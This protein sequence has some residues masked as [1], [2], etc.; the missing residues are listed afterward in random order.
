MILFI[1]KPFIAGV[2]TEHHYSL[3]PYP[4]ARSP[5]K[6]VAK[7]LKSFPSAKYSRMISIG[8]LKSLAIRLSS[9]PQYRGLLKNLL[10]HI[11]TGQNATAQK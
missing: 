4:L 5:R 8:L 3:F 1:K 10:I 6:S 2:T 7:L 11:Y 9:F